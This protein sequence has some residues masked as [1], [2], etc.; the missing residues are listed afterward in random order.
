MDSWHL[1]Q[2][3]NQLTVNALDEN[4]R[5]QIPTFWKEALLNYLRCKLWVKEKKTQKFQLLEESKLFFLKRSKTSILD[6]MWF[7]R[8]QH[9]L[10]LQGQ[11]LFN[12]SWTSLDRAFYRWRILKIP[13]PPFQVTTQVMLFLPIWYNW[14]FFP[15]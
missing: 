1:R 11:N 15:H 7:M 3:S 10:H 5:N 8:S 4:T 9:P 12:S 6:W 2:F 13:P 14:L